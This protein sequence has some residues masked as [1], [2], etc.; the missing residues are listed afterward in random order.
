MEALQKSASGIG[1]MSR[2]ALMH[3]VRTVMGSVYNDF[4]HKK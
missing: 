2:A 4:G 3:C 1:L